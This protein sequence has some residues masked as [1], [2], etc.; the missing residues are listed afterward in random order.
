MLEFIIS[1]PTFGFSL[2]I[3]SY[4]VALAIKNR[5]NYTLLN[6]LLVGS[7][8]V[9]AILGIFKIPLEKFLTG[10][11][12]VSMFLG[13]ATAAL[14]ISMYNQLDTI[15][16]NLL[17]ILVGSVVGALSA[18]ASILLLCKLFGLNAEMT[19]SLLPKSITTA[20]GTELS[21]QLGGIVPITVAAISTTG[22]FG[23]ITAPYLIKLLKIN[24]SVASGLAIGASS[25][26]LGT[27]KAIELGEV[28]GSI[29][30]IAVGLCGVVTVI[31]AIFL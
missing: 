23:A 16:K 8:I 28:E 25:H 29:S 18:V 22:I 10:A 9:I 17:P 5:F 13:P 24:N 2:C 1:G 21:N 19:A 30:S 3:A 26:V 15:K 27:S 7:L 6:P 14:A 12:F 4:A 31:I 11:N 20:F